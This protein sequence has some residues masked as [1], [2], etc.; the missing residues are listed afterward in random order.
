MADK[1]LTAKT[2]RQKILAIA[3]AIILIIIIWQII[4]LFGGSAGSEPTTMARGGTPQQQPRIQP[5]APERVAEVPKP[6]T[7]AMTPLEM[8]LMRLQQETQAKYVAAL[9]QLQMLKLEKDIAESEKDIMKAKQET[10]TAQKNIVDL[11]APPV[12]QATPA[13]YAQ[14]LVTP[15]GT[16]ASGA[17]ITSSASNSEVKYSVISVSQLQSRW[18]A[19]L[20]YQG[21]LYSVFIGDILPP[22]GSKVLSINRSGVVLE[23][24]NQRIKV[25]MVPVI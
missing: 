23:K 16:S 4:G 6:K 11:L 22:D 3:F 21:N 15:S 2:S 9:N 19:V 20:G 5:P 7:E 18:S 8:E 24:D 1:I 13:T 10:V 25:S 17:S 12:A 14:N